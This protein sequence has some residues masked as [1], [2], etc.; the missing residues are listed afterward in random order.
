MSD[1]LRAAKPSRPR[2]PNSGEDGGSP[3]AL[4]AP[5]ASNT[6][7]VQNGSGFFKRLGEKLKRFYRVLPDEERNKAFWTFTLGQSLAT[8]G[9]DFH[10]TALPNLVAPTKADTA[11]LGYNRATNWGAQAAG[12]LLTGPFVDRHPV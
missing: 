6:A 3:L 7:P 5:G 10:Y 12:S 2:P 11:K 8:L 1:A 4:V 9:M